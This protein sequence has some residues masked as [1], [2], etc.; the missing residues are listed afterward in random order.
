MA[1]ESDSL[2]LKHRNCIPETPGSITGIVIFQTALRGN[3]PP[4]RIKTFKDL[5]NWEDWGSGGS[6]PG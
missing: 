3:M 2:E 5:K 4:S 1:A 6:A